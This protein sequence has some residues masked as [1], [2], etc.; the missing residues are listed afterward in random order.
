M[1]NYKRNRLRTTTVSNKKYKWK[2]VNEKIGITLKIWYNKELLVEEWY[3][4][5]K[6]IHPNQVKKIIQKEKL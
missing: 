4:S 6:D 3:V 1:Q 2:I 5:K